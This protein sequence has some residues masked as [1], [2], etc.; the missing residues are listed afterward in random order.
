MFI[1]I[2][3]IL[4]W[5]WCCWDDAAVLL[6]LFLCDG[7]D[8]NSC[9]WSMLL[10]CWWSFDDWW[11]MINNYASVRKHR[12]HISKL[13]PYIPSKML[14]GIW[15]DRHFTLDPSAWHVNEPTNYFRGMSC[16]LLYCIITITT[17]IITPQQH[18]NNHLN[19]TPITSIPTPIT[20]IPTHLSSSSNIIIARH[21]HI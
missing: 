16:L 8:D 15:Y 20:S 21:N 1:R 6:L 9:W 7:E 19:T 13:H 2:I 18:Y 11:L 17:T 12:L 3:H 4:L 14:I 10:W 5:Y